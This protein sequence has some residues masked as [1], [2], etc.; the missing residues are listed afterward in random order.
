MNWSIIVFYKILGVLSLTKYADVKR[1]G[2]KYVRMADS[3]ITSFSLKVS[4]IENK[5]RHKII[6]SSSKHIY[7]VYV[8][9]G[10]KKL[11]GPLENVKIAVQ[12]GGQ[13]N[14]IIVS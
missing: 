14:M 2:G 3:Q 4:S 11:I 12:I 6:N 13:P 9:P 10:L 7:Y 1:N 5:L 8:V